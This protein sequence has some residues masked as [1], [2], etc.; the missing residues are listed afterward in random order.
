MKRIAK[1][2][3]ISDLSDA[4][5]KAAVEHCTFDWM[6]EHAD[7]YAPP[8][9]DVAFEGGAKTFINKGTNGRWRDILS[10]E[11]N[12]RYRAKAEA[13]LGEECAKWLENGRLA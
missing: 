10:E 12:A 4:E 5:W 9:S 6:K 2:L 3:D 1:F 13:E 7:Q 8:Q 11:D